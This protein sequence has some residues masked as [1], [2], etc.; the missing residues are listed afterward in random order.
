MARELHTQDVTAEPGRNALN[1]LLIRLAGF[2]KTRNP[3][4][5]PKLYQEAVA[6]AREMVQADPRGQTKHVTLA[7]SLAPAGNHAEA[8]QIADK[9]LAGVSKVDAELLIDMARVYSQCSAAA[10]LNESEASAFRDR[11]LE[12]LSKAVAQEFRDPFYLTFHPDF[13]P[14]QSAQPFLDLVKQ[15]QLAK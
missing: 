8:S 15:L 14:L 9:L 2:E 12:C 5:S 13:A 1:I 3:E 11:A 7:L 6:I 10:G 4:I